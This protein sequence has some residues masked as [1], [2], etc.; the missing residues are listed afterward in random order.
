MSGF[1]LLI[2]KDKSK[3]DADPDTHV[4]INIYFNLLQLLT[5]HSSTDRSILLVNRIETVR[6]V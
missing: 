2:R 6:E 4:N 1:T 5:I 3:Q